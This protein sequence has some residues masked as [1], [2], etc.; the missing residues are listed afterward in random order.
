MDASFINNSSSSGGVPSL[1][2][3]ISNV[4]ASLGLGGASQTS[5]KTQPGPGAATGSGNVSND[6][7]I[8]SSSDM[9]SSLPE[10]PSTLPF[11]NFVALNTGDFRNTYGYEFVIYDSIKNQNIDSIL[12]PISP[13]H[14]TQS[15][16]PAINT[17][18][19]MKGIIEEHNGAPLRNISIAGTMGVMPLDIGVKGTQSSSTSI[20]SY[21]NTIFKNTI[22]SVNNA[23]G[24]I[25]QVANSFNSAAGMV[26]SKLNYP[27][28]QLNPQGMNDNNS[29][30][31]YIHRLL[32]FL[33]YYL[34]L[35]KSSANRGYRLVFQMYK[36]QMY[37]DCTLGPYNFDKAQG[38]VEYTYSIQLT[39]WNRRPNPVATDRSSLVGNGS[40]KPS[41]AN[42]LNKLQQALNALQQTRQALFAVSNILGGINADITNSFIQ[43]LQDIN[44]IVKDALNIGLTMSDFITGK[45]GN[46]FFTGSYPTLVAAA[47]V[48]PPT[49]PDQI[50]QAG[51]TG[52]STAQ[53]G[54]ALASAQIAQKA[55]GVASTAVTNQPV[56]NPLQTMLNNPLPYTAILDQIPINS[57]PL[58]AAAQAQV[59]AA[60]DRVRS[61]TSQDFQDRRDLIQSFATTISA[62][63]GGTN[64]T[65]NRIF[66]L[67][68]PP[69][70]FRQLTTDDIQILSG[71]NDC[72]RLAD[73][74]ITTIKN[75]SGQTSTDYYSFYRDYAV[76]NGLTFTDSVSKF[77]VPFPLGATMESLAVQYLGDADRWIEIAAL[78]GL[79][80]PYIDETGFVL[81]LIGNG[82]GNYVT[83]SS[84]PNIYIGQIVVLSSSTQFNTQFK[85]LS[86]DVV[87]NTQ[88]VLELSGPIPLSSFTVADSAQ[89][90]AY[91]PNT[92]NS[93]RLIAIPSL[94]PVSPAVGS[95]KGLPGVQD[96][97]G[98][99]ALA[100]VDFLLDSS[101]DLIISSSGD[102]ALAIG[103]A[104]LTQVA[105]MILKTPIGSIVSDP[106]FGNPI[107]PGVNTADI[108][109]TDAIAQL[110]KTFASDPRFSGVLAAN[111]NKTGP[112]VSIQIALKIAGS[113]KVLP[114]STQ[115]P[116]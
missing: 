57:L 51:F 108:N 17:T 65:Y 70:T 18:V 35:K 60:V 59:T 87:S 102:I 99:V 47:D 26:S 40:R 30:Y 94:S 68:T 2:Q 112:A 56:I 110:D 79:M 5:A 24:Q 11:I 43:P 105:L 39:A 69:N 104:N 67:P 74:V 38:S 90:L 116:L 53:G 100:Q 7:A 13:Q 45:S 34:E 48:L 46:A 86:I 66:G 10:D 91:A 1:N 111:I 31:S 4:Q 106:T 63:F 107:Q 50:S 64:A 78:N 44:M 92:V 101:G 19:T 62:S 29:G 77:F 58:T 37:Y 54:S 82:S 98:L 72:V 36:D 113:G 61:L 49:L 32:R 16:V 12:L 22:Q 103:L 73:T 115:L 28:A 80:A 14:I 83:V 41:Q 88:T 9:T 20:T 52:T 96:L 42:Q 55:S 15:V 114:I 3:E 25:N 23:V 89:I 27:V 33:D 21:L 95:T 84:A 93:Q 6:W 81:P 75:I 85:V 71:L 76:A 8:L 109:P 97:S